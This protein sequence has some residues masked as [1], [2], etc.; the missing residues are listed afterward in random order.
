MRTSNRVLATSA[1]LVL[2]MATFLMGVAHAADVRHDFTI[3]AGPLSTALNAL[4]TQ[5]HT[6]ILYAPQVVDG[7]S[8]A[9]LSG[10]YSVNEALARLLSGTGLHS[11]SVNETT[12]A[13]SVAPVPKDGTQD[14]RRKEEPVQ[15]E[16]IVVSAA[17][18]GERSLLDTPLAI[19]AFDGNWLENNG[20]R[21]MND[22]IQLAP[23]VSMVQLQPGE[24]R[25][26]M[27]GISANIGE[28]A[29]GYYL[30]EVPMSFINQVGL[31]DIRAFDMD[32]IEI[33]RGPQGTLYGAGALGGVVRSI[34]HK[35]SLDEY[36]LKTDFSV[37]ST[38][39]GG[40]N[41]AGNV[42]AN[43]PLVN[44]RLGLRAVL[45]REDNS[46]WVDH[47][48]INKPNYNSDDL[49]AGRL[50]LLGR[51]NDQLTI[52]GLYWHSETSSFASPAAF[53]DMT[54][55]ELSAT[56]SSWS[57]DIYNVTLNYDTPT[58]HL[59]SST[60]HM[61]MDVDQQ[62]DYF[63]GYALR[64][65]LNPRAW[66]QEVRAYS[67]NDS[68]WQWSGGVFY[69]W[70]DQTQV[71][72]SPLFAISG[73]DPVEQY[74]KVISKSVFGEAT[75]RMF[76]D[77]LELTVGARV[78]DETR[79]SLQLFPAPTD[80]YGKTFHAV[81]PRVSLAYHPAKNWMIYGDYSQGYRSGT[82]QFAIVRETAAALGVIL[83][84]TVEPERADS[85]ELG[86]KGS[87]LDNRLTVDA[88]VFTLKWHDMQ[89]I[90]PIVQNQLYAT[91]NA[92]GA[93][94]SGVEFTVRMRVGSHLQVGVTGSWV[95]ATIDA[96]VVAQAQVLDPVTGEPSGASV[97]IVVYKKGDRISDVPRTTAGL[98]A[99]YT[100][101]LPHGGL[102]FVAHASAQYAAAREQVS[103]TTVT[104][105]D[106]VTIVDARVG[107]EAMRWGLYLF[108]SNL[109]NNKALIT[110][111]DANDY[112]PR[113]RPRTVG[114]NF[115]YQF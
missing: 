90:V 4:A 44:D 35:P 5:S 39:S 115:K 106:P 92:A 69:R 85:Y 93:S 56:P 86:V 27:R 63:G 55:D 110:P 113:P 54:S 21:G 82:N 76:E 19:S 66:T 99:D 111:F 114:V 2:F 53:R 8:T 68:P 34:T 41:Y 42:A 23:G 45:T 98:T 77:R 65:T 12:W 103:F 40:T 64:T 17:R 80:P 11:R 58:F 13:I 71:Q 16:S 7:K 30:D 28:N 81:T 107:L 88:D 112:G 104:T 96:D 57:Y 78:L 49:T 67:T 1:A 48:A 87:F 25:I 109:L 51:V 89:T 22:F 72:D 97:P 50:E 70:V 31:P 101:P 46:G 83:P 74:D 15:L 18:T 38:A 37:S 62:N 79:S 105:G 60:S 36:Q 75:R 84:S 52:S 73:Q 47:P 91:L 14:V 61:A 95:D 102:N 24:N 108:G 20:F 26:Q 100:Y 59:V 94:S 6:Q 29:V 10:S 43:A 32:R 9:G 3:P 33:L